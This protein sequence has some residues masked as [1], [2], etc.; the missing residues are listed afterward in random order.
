MYIENPKTKGSGVICAIPQSGKCP[1]GCKDCFYQ[2][3]RSYLE[4]LETNLPNLP[5]IELT[6]G[7]VVRFN[8]GNDSNNQR[9]L[10]LEEAKKYEH[11][12]FNT[13]MMT[14]LA[15]FERPVVLTVNP[16][17]LTDVRFH[18]IFP[19]P[20]NLMFVRFRTNMWNL[21]LC[22][23]AVDFYTSKGTPVV[24]T[25]MAYYTEAI[26]EIYQKYYELKKRTLNEYQVMT[27]RAWDE[28]MYRYKD[29]VLVY[30]CGK[31]AGVYSC[32]RCGNCLREYFATI[33]K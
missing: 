5:P 17:N 32:A 10:V 7:K 19:V 6:K 21:K 2:S 31:N 29:N 4:P 11:V 23:D 27:Q 24:L 14:D 8:D 22:D 15:G 30:S 26:P 3:G 33:N 18:T 1:V 20:K 9:E 28:V 16:G 25:F 12:F 13:S